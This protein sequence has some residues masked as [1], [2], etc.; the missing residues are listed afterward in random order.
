VAG[1][2]PVPTGWVQVKQSSVTPEMTAWATEIVKNTK[3]YPMCSSTTQTFGAAT[4]LAR[5]EWH[6]PDFNVATVH[7]GVTLF[8]RDTRPLGAALNLPGASAR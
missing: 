2:P 8:E 5:V 6:A 3:T 1:N 4:F 7:R